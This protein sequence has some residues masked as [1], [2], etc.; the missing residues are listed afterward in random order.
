MKV[1]VNLDV[2]H[3]GHAL[4]DLWWVEAEE[5]LHQLAVDKFVEHEAAYLTTNPNEHEVWMYITKVLRKMQDKGD[6]KVAF[7][8]GRRPEEIVTEKKTQALRASIINDRCSGVTKD[9]YQTT[10]RAL[11]AEEGSYVLMH[12]ALWEKG[13]LHCTH[14]TCAV[15]ERCITCTSPL[16][17]YRTLHTTAP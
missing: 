15:R 4:N 2:V 7:L 6:P 10:L 3:C 9:V 1:E 12:R 11:N 5:L 13:V 8:R 14:A 16:S 17:T